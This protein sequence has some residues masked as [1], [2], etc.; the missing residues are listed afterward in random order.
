MCARTSMRTPSDDRALMALSRLYRLASSLFVPP[1]E[2]VLE[3]LD[4]GELVDGARTSAR[5]LGS[6]GI[7]AAVEGLAAAWAENPAPDLEGLLEQFEVAYGQ[8]CTADRPP[9]ELMYGGTTPFR[10][11]QDLADL[12]GYYRA[13]NVS[14]APLMHE[15]PDHVGVE[16]EFV[17]YLCYLAAWAAANGKEEQHQTAL[18]AARSFLRDHLGTFATT[19]AQRAAATAPP[20]VFRQGAALLAALVAEHCDAVGIER[21][22]RRYLDPSAF[23]QAEEG[24]LA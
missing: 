5:E 4:S 20:S 1:G 8:A 6:E 9:Y 17:S 19:F 2:D 7:R 18:A 22:E 21:R 23:A 10:E 3:S 11:P 12:S 14:L 16:A 13:F 24:D 15:R